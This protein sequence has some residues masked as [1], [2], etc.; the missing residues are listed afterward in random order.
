MLSVDALTQVCSLSLPRHQDGVG[1]EQSVP[2]LAAPKF[3]LAKL[4]FNIVNLQS[5]QRNQFEEQ[6]HM[7]EAE[8]LE[9]A[10]LK[11][12]AIGIRHEEI[13]YRDGIPATKWEFIDVADLVAM[14]SPIKSTEIYTQTHET[15]EAGAYIHHVHQRG[16]AIRLNF[17]R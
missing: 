9:E 13:I 12:R 5:S 3:Y 1:P 14:P 17:I 2:L 6:L 16:K 10:F 8:S 4:I 7:V 15:D 11:S